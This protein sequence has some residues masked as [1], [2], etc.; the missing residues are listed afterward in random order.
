MA[1]EILPCTLVWLG[2]HFVWLKH[3]SFVRKM[4]VRFQLF[5]MDIGAVGVAQCVNNDDAGDG[6]SLDSFDSVNLNELH[7]LH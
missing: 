5:V 3:T 4:F 1:I 7:N 2:Q 6:G